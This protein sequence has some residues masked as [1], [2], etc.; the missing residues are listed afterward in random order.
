MKIIS[1]DNSRGM[2]SKVL[3]SQVNLQLVINAKRHMK[4][5]Y[6]IFINTF[7]KYFILVFNYKI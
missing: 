7:F 1:I 4:V 6:L 5:F 3:L 2:C